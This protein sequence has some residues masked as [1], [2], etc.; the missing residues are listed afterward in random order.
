MD[1]FYY[2]FFYFQ[3]TL[4]M[5]TTSRWILFITEDKQQKLVLIHRIKNGR[6]YY[7][8]PWGH[9]EQGETPVQ[10]LIREIKE[11]LSI[12]VTIQKLFKEYENTDLWRHEY[13]YLCQQTWWTIQLG[14]WPEF[15]RD[16]AENF[17]EIVKIPV[18][19][20]SDY[21]ILP[22]EIISTLPRLLDASLSVA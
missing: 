16:P 2:N 14:D 5:S 10:T 13:F 7:T 20:L 22:V 12:D 6:E 18:N 4:Y 11:E 1:N 9:V 17:Y 15:K 21:P 8:F 3:D 19:E